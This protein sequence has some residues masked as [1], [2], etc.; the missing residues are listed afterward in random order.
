MVP[1]LRLLV[2]APQKSGE[3]FLKN[4]RPEIQAISI[5]LIELTPP[6]GGFGE[7]DPVIR[8]LADF[9]WLILTSQVAA[10]LFFQRVSD[11]QV[12]VPTTLSIVV[13]GE[14]SGEVLKEF[15]LS[16]F[17]M[18]EIASSAGLI[19]FFK[20][21]DMAAK[22]VLFP[23]SAQ[24]RM[25]CGDYLSQRGAIVTSLTLYETNYRIPTLHEKNILVQGSYEGVL[26]T[27]PMQVGAFQRIKDLSALAG[28]KIFAIGET[29][30]GELKKYGLTAH[31]P[32]NP[33]MEE[34]LALI[35]RKFNLG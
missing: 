6:K 17:Y 21:R 24:G 20:S 32:E 28:K 15:G 27:S 7:I 9:D 12:S 29:T 16:T 5:P 31:V 18:P 3:I 33:L 22:R 11:L 19:D 8:S 14:K 10:D 30:A 13:M 1:P 23:R 35:E 2:C 25:E 26:F 34:M 4:C